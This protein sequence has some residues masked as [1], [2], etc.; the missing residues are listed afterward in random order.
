MKC[1]SSTLIGN[2]A[3]HVP[4]GMNPTMPGWCVH[5][6]E[7][8]PCVSNFDC[9]EG[10]CVSLG[11][12]RYCIPRQGFGSAASEGQSGKKPTAP[13]AGLGKWIMLKQSRVS[14]DVSHP[15]LTEILMRLV[16]IDSDGILLL[17]GF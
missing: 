16:D 7:L 15:I 3:S 5:E 1:Y 12:H 11:Q 14:L 8:E 13:K 6:K 2:A 9:E 4:A 17:L 10:K